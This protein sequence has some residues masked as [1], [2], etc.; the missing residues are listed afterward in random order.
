MTNKYLER[1]AQHPQPSEKKPVL[2]SHLTRVEWVSSRK[3]TTKVD[4][5]VGIKK[6]IFTT[7][8]N[9]NAATM[10]ISLNISQKKK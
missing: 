7:Y 3:Q 6:A 9:I 2:I 1:N 10:D 8:E 5:D 4:K